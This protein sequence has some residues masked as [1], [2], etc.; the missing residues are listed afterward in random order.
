MKKKEI[1]L[2]RKNKINVRYFY[3][4]SR[5]NFIYFNELKKEMNIHSV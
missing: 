4:F 2:P 3:A 1:T 5:Q